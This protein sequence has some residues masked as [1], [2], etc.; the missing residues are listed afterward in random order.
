MENLPGYVMYTYGPVI[1]RRLSYGT[2]Q[3][4]IVE[5]VFKLKSSSTKLSSRLLIH[6]NKARNRPIKLTQKYILQ[7]KLLDNNTSHYN[8]ILLMTHE[9]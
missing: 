8:T 3:E 1:M 9:Q 5:T 6:A 4:N 2:S 7:N